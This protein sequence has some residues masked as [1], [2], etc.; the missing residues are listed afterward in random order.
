MSIHIFED[1]KSR[2]YDKDR[3]KGVDL[4]LNYVLRA[5]TEVENTTSAI[6]TALKLE[7]PAKYLG[8]WLLSYN[9]KPLGGGVWEGEAKYGPIDGEEIDPND[10]KPQKDKDD[11]FTPEQEFEVLGGNQRVTQSIV[12]L[13]KAGPNGSGNDYINN[14]G[15]ADDPDAPNFEKAIGVTRDR[16][17]GVDFPPVGTISH[18]KTYIMPSS[19]ITHGYLEKLVGLVNTTNSEEWWGRPPEQWLFLG[20]RGKSKSVSE[21]TVTFNFMTG[22][23]TF[24]IPV[25]TFT[26]KAKNP[27]D[28]LW[29]YYKKK[30][31][32]GRTIQVPAFAYVEKVVPNRSFTLLGVT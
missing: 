15:G 26:V 2:G 14:T 28:Y 4:R 27:F 31:S 22:V 25:G 9:A 16:V 32:S 5:T 1:I 17:E 21:W 24:D 11:P 18:S 19:M 29:V 6:E 8:L 7:I 30:E 10:P 20:A 13:I 23:P 12:T 3:K